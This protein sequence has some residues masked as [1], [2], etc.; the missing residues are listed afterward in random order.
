MNPDCSSHIGVRV[1]NYTYKFE[2]DIIES[3]ALGRDPPSSAIFP[4]DGMPANHPKV[5]NQICGEQLYAGAPI[6]A[7]GLWSRDGATASSDSSCETQVSGQFFYAYDYPS[8]SSGNTGFVNPDAITLYTVMDVLER[9]YL[10]ITLDSPGNQYPSEGDYGKNMSVTFTSEGLVGLATPPAV[11]QGD[12]PAEV[13]NWDA[14]TGT[15][16]ANWRWKPCCTDGAVIGPIP[17]SNFSLTMTVNSYGIPTTNAVRVGSYNYTN[18]EVDFAMANLGAAPYQIKLTAFLTEA[19]CNTFTS[20]GA[21]TV[22]P[23]CQF[24]D[25]MCEQ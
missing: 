14:A 20:C 22:E 25:N 1:S 19:Y 10:V 7:T 23:G 15:A 11:V 16:T 24:C 9:V 5:T 3:Q 6:P 12:D 8:R 2:W 17:D 13:S 18:S 4:I 21:C